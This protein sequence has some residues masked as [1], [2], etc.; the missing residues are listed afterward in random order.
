MKN[1]RFSAI[2]VLTVAGV[3]AGSSVVL[4]EETICQGTIGAVTVDN[5]RV[6]DS[7]TCALNGTIVQGTVKVES[8]A[9]LKASGARVAGN[10]QAENAA[11]V[12]VS[13]SVT[14]GS[15]QFKQ[16]KMASVANSQIN[17]DLQG[18]PEYRR[19]VNCEQ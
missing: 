13:D 14:G 1:T 3:L 16:G 15:I 18:L 11:A 10:I 2:A 7:K 9:T 4:A 19:T 6:P 12:S 8:N 17:G 5:V